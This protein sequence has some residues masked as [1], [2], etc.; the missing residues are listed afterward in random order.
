MPSVTSSLSH[1]P[2]QNQVTEMLRDELIQADVIAALVGLC[3]EHDF[4]GVVLEFLSQIGQNVISHRRQVRSARSARV[5]GLDSRDKR[6]RGWRMLCARIGLA[7][8]FSLIPFVARPTS[9]GVGLGGAHWQGVQGRGSNPGHRGPAEPIG[10]SKGRHRGAVRGRLL[11]INDLRTPPG[12]CCGGGLCVVAVGCCC[13]LLWLMWVVVV[14]AAVGLWLLLL[15]AA[16]VV[17][18]AVGLWLLLLWVAVVVVVV[19]VVVGCCC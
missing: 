16:V 3:R 4:D 12:C 13:G 15:W 7:A 14:V 2:A 19:V 18:V 8:L 17:V 9:A 10:D 6:W 1:P 11:S 5:C